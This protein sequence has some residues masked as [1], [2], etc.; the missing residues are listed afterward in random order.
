ME[1][2]QC[3]WHVSLGWACGTNCRRANCHMALYIIRDQ[4]LHFWIR[5]TNDGFFRSDH[6][7]GHG[8]ARRAHHPALRPLRRG[9]HARGRRLL[10]IEEVQSRSQRLPAGRSSPIFTKGLY[11]VLWLWLQ[12]RLRCRCWMSGHMAR[13]GATGRRPSWCLRVWC[14]ASGS[15]PDTDGRVLTLQRAVFWWKGSFRPWARRSGRSVCCVLACCAFFAG[16][17]AGTQRLS[18]QLL[19]CAGGRVRARPSSGSSPVLAVVGPRPLSGDWRVP[20]PR[21][22][23]DGAQRTGTPP[24][25]AVHTVFCCWSSSIFSKHW[26]TGAVCLAPGSVHPA[27]E[28]AWC[29]PRAGTARWSL[30]HQRLTREACRRLAYYSAAPAT[31]LALELGFA[32][33]AYFSRFFKRRTGKSPQRWRQTWQAQGEAVTA[34]IRSGK[35]AL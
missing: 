10:H 25:G 28:P 31:S 8:P 3:S 12:M 21:D 27:A 34:L 24:P 33:P 1:A 5:Q 35:T 9:G 17:W 14:T 20:V 32:D 19:G 16:R 11:Q 6:G 26:P 18:V 29:V 15:R 7:H 4:I 2:A 13:I 22:A 23:R 30:V